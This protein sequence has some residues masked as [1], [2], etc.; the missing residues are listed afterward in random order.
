MVVRAQDL[1]VGAPATHGTELELD[2]TLAR[3]GNSSV[4][5]AERA[6]RVADGVEVARAFVT[7][8]VLD[9][10][11][12]PTRVPDVIRAAVE[13]EE[14]PSTPS[15]AQAVPHDA[16]SRT[17]SIRPSDLDTLLHVNQSRYVDF[18]DDTRTLR[19]AAVPGA[20]S[21]PHPSRIVL[22]YRRETHM[23]HDLLARACALDDDANTLAVDLCDAI[24]GELV[25]RA[26]IS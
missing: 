10:A 24:D 11:N 9:G 23:G 2:L 6:T 13:A 15:F 19:K 26:R 1:W 16:F 12:K 20:P 8:V 3:V 22:D 21:L 25:S 14:I 5:F 4:T 17:V 18:V 7:G